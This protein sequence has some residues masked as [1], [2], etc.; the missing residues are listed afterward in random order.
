M[1]NTWIV[2]EAKGHHRYQVALVVQFDRLLHENVNNSWTTSLGFCCVLNDDKAGAKYLCLVRVRPSCS[3][4]AISGATSHPALREVVQ[5]GHHSFPL[6]E[7]LRARRAAIHT[8]PWNYERS[9]SIG[10]CLAVGKCA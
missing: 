3:Q 6:E 9:Y 7:R 4:P 8:V 1:L 2:A 5:N 10:F